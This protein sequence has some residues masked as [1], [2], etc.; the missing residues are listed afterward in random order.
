MT[1]RYSNLTLGCSFNARGILRICCKSKVKRKFDSSRHRFLE[2]RF[3]FRKSSCYFPWQLL[4]STNTS[5]S[6]AYACLHIHVHGL[7]LTSRTLSLVQ[8]N[9][10]GRP[11][12]KAGLTCK[13]LYDSYDTTCCSRCVLQQRTA[14]A[15]R[16]GK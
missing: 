7:S 4:R 13:I 14:P 6:L 12:G 3:R 11:V 16:H 10:D 1:C 9:A 5:G 15:I 8:W 2:N